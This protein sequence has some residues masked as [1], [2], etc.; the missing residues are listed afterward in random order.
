[1]AQVKATAERTVAAAPDRVRQ[2]LADYTATRPKLLTEHFSEYEVREGGTGA[3]TVVHWK[4]AATSKRVRDCLIH[5]SEAA[6]GLVEKDENSSMVTS[7][8]VRPAGEAASTVSIETTWNGAGGVGGFF[9]RTFA[10]LGLR[11]IYDGVLAKLDTIVTDT[12][13]EN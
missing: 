7:W 12:V 4:L 13:T 9:E 3:G 11:R 1:M 2:A 6:D 10:P 8:T 5:V